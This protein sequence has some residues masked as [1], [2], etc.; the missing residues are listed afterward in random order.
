[1]GNFFTDNDN[2]KIH[3]S[4]PLMKK[5]VRLK[6]R[7]YTDKETCDYAPL[8]FEDA[9]DSYDKIL[10]IIGE[11]SGDIIAPNADAV[12][13]EGPAL[14][15]NK[16]LYA[17]GTQ[18]NI[19]AMI[20]SGLMGFS[21]PR[22]VGGLNM[23]LT[24]YIMA[25]EI[26][27]RA[28]ASFTNIFGL[29][30]CAETLHEFANED[31]NNKTPSII[32][33]R[34]HSS[35]GADRARCR[36]RPAGVQLRAVYDEE[37]KCWRLTGVKRF[38]TNGGGEILLVLARSEE[39]TKDG[40]GLSLFVLKTDNTVRIRRIEHKL[41]ITGSPTCEMVFCNTPAQL[42]GERRMGLIKYV[43]SLMNAARLGIGAQ[44]VGIA[45]AGTE[46]L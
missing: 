18:R 7:N 39:G 4:H 19:D 5:I 37:A 20:S 8:D 42:V 36:F 11:I 38:I 17:K 1:M 3:L 33:R 34:Q 24:I 16:V 45:E 12:D 28:D 30:D 41:G 21:L 10:E 26:I 40:R 22:N 15:D 9:M 29:Q 6:E 27:A 46:K 25:A 44:S 13:K 23:P 43:M 32:F 31:I 35:N 2:F 14:K